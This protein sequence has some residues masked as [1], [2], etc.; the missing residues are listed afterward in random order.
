MR[1]GNGIVQHFK[2]EKNCYNCPMQ[3]EKRQSTKVLGEQ[4]NWDFMD[5]GDSG[6]LPTLIRSG[7]T[8][9]MICYGRKIYYLPVYPILT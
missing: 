7:G 8:Q 9:A 1:K 2:N 5:L 3:K 6:T 4:S